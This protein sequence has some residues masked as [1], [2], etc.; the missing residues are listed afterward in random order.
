MEERPHIIRTQQV[1][2]GIEQESRSAS[3]QDQA[4]RLCHEKLPALFE[5]VM[6]ECIPEKLRIT[7]NTLV[8]DLG[9]IPADRFETEF[10][11]RAKEE[12]RKQLLRLK[13][14]T[15][16]D[17]HKTYLQDALEHFLLHGTLPWWISDP[18]DNFAEETLLGLLASAPDEL[19]R[20]IRRI[21]RK[22]Q[23][24]KRLARQFSE[25]ALIRLVEKLEPANARTILEYAEKLQQKQEKERV[26]NAENKDFKKAIW[27]FIL[28]YLLHEKGSYFN[29]RAF[30][31]SLITRLAAHYNLSYLTLL[32]HLTLSAEEIGISPSQKHSLPRMLQLLLE[33]EMQSLI[34]KGQHSLNVTSLQNSRNLYTDP[35]SKKNTLSD[36]GPGVNDFPEQENRR[37]DFQ[38]AI[39][40]F[41]PPDALTTADTLADSPQSKMP[42]TAE[43]HTQQEQTAYLLWYYLRTGSL[44]G[45]ASIRASALEAGWKMLLQEKPNLLRS[46]VSRWKDTYA[47][48]QRLIAFL[49]PVLV[50][51][52]I[53][54]LAPSVGKEFNRIAAQWSQS[55]AALPGMSGF[56]R[57]QLSQHWIACTLAT[58][59]QPDKLPQHLILSLSR[60]TGIAPPLLA[61]TLQAPPL[62]QEILR[63]STPETWTKVLSE[64]P[65]KEQ[66]AVTP[67]NAA[68]TEATRSPRAMADRLIFFLIQGS[69]PWWAPE[70]DQEQLRQHYR[71]LSQQQP[72][73]LRKALY[74][75]SLSENWFTHWKTLLPSPGLTLA[76]IDPVSASTSL[77]YWQHFSRSDA[78]KSEKWPG[79]LF[80]DATQEL[81]LT[82]LLQYRR[83]GQTARAFTTALL[84]RIAR[85]YG[86]KAVDFAATLFAY[87]ENFS[88]T[89]PSLMTETLWLCSGE[90]SAE[91]REDLAE[92]N[93]WATDKKEKSN[94][95]DSVS[96][97][98]SKRKNEVS[99]TEATN[100][101]SETGNKD[102][103]LQE[104]GENEKN[105]PEPHR[106]ETPSAHDIVQDQ[107]S[108]AFSASRSKSEK[109]KNQDDSK[110]ESGSLKKEENFLPDIPQKIQSIQDTS[111]ASHVQP[112][113]SQE[114]NS[115]LKAK[116][117]GNESSESK[118]NTTEFSDLKSKIAYPKK[119]RNS[120]KKEKDDRLKNTPA[121][122][123][124]A[125]ALAALSEKL[126]KLA[127]YLQS[128][129]TPAGTRPEELAAWLKDL[130]KKEPEAT[131][132]KLAPL[133]KSRQ[134][135]LRISERKPPEWVCLLLDMLHQNRA[136]SLA[137]LL[138][139]WE[140]LRQALPDLA[141]LLPL[142]KLRN[143]SLELALQKN[144][145]SAFAYIE[146]SWAYVQSQVSAEKQQ[147][148]L[149]N[150][151]A[152]VVSEKGKFTR[153][154]H[155]ALQLL[156][157]EMRQK[158]KDGKK[159]EEEEL[160]EEEAEKEE[161][162]ENKEGVF[163]NNAGLVL[164][165]PF[166]GALFERN[167]L[168]SDRKFSDEK[169]AF[170]AV[171]LLQFLAC[172]KEH[173]PEYQLVLNKILCGISPAV[174][175]NEP[176]T[177][178][179]KE[180]Q[181]AQSLLETVIRQWRII[182]NTSVEG[183]RETFLMRA[184]K[185][186]TE[187]EYLRLHVE[188]KA[189]DMLL[190]QLPWS[191]SII[192]LPWMKK[193]I[194]VTWR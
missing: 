43:K 22:T 153:A 152:Y 106:Q 116:K 175:L 35:S 60:S 42:A 145:A 32:H 104:K 86:I 81:I 160:P 34:G 165:W 114:K 181:D 58:P 157:E 100:L 162:E 168:L 97:E 170:R 36:F 56:S 69:L 109:T 178:N 25:P 137:D 68:H 87:C 101:P 76:A 28:H 50:E 127:L 83:S 15:R 10:P 14:E 166:L 27:E 21:G 176:V 77:Q 132:K 59:A 57:T 30:L 78:P 192:R 2:L 183:L 163:V 174:P 135:R 73:R 115:P 5:E 111:D 113:S 138:L 18:G 20:L 3:L 187:N 47:L 85:K 31:K 194:H 49:S 105:L 158:I 82:W 98:K 8:L 51:Q 123:P 141:A 169:N 84:Q 29:T 75:A 193:P 156:R 4:S 142:S 88:S 24:R 164:L 94:I 110:K 91:W 112:L 26:T 66:H 173:L 93:E 188:K 65:E 6:R 154:F 52:T 190:D 180:K 53:A 124:E 128:G 146:M 120:T 107:E 155:A 161:E 37:P 99:E 126:E 150:M 139:D 40:T 129:Q 184:G 133:L 92:K 130:L 12:L 148:L 189:Y 125:A 191:Y 64:N 80:I 71:Q 182:G 151:Y 72:L 11:E 172:G 185:L 136:F 74:Q 177:L 171:H 9:T 23:V 70:S 186:E 44:P 89:I 33:E 167:G 140:R 38:K 122:T 67:V 149:G 119:D 118:E 7:L 147:V 121:L 95:A 96:A 16:Y 13:K 108:T 179:E 19:I 117:A 39:E 103:Y 45:T 134:I 55:I 62:R 90:M 46:V 54:F 102:L 61:Q 144:K 48:S 1:E 159:S 41:L 79:S 63:F 143:L 131:Y 17:Q